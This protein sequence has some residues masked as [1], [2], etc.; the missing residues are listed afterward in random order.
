MYTHSDGTRYNRDFEKVEWTEEEEMEMKE[1]KKRLATFNALKEA[2]ISENMTKFESLLESCEDPN[3]YDG[4]YEP[5]MAT[6]INLA[7]EKAI[8]MLIN[9]GAN[10]DVTTD[11]KETCLTIA[12]KLRVGN[13]SKDVIYSSALLELV[14]NKLDSE[15]SKEYKLMLINILFEYNDNTPLLLAFKSGSKTMTDLIIKHGGDI[16][17]QFFLK[18][19]FSKDANDDECRNIATLLLQYGM[20]PTLQITDAVKN[21]HIKTASLLLTYNSNVEPKISSILRY[22]IPLLDA[23][24]NLDF[25]MA[26]MLLDNGC[27]AGKGNVLKTLM[28]SLNVYYKHPGLK[29]MQATE[30]MA[31]RLIEK[32]CDVNYTDA[33]GET[34]I[35]SLCK[36][37]WD[38][39][40]LVKLLILHGANINHKCMS[41]LLPIMIACFYGNAHIN[42][43]N[44]LFSKGA[45]KNMNDYD[46]R[47]TMN[48]TNNKPIHDRFKAELKWRAR[49]D[50][51]LVKKKSPIFSK[52]PDEMV[53]KVA[54]YLDYEDWNTFFKIQGRRR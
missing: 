20:N 1:K 39:S 38:T 40:D 9:R 49:K 22:D 29:D 21:G 8:T 43:I 23:I 28:T 16:D 53:R 33:L 2:L 19:V 25:D 44:L 10:V 31:Q 17:G 41:G 6:A 27:T 34:P 30:K 4:N 54:C 14:L 11:D 12:F 46:I 37:Y 32:G 5:I 45:L 35:M 26:N 48:K 7:N 24:K 50:L 51:L 47:H 15:V 18:K 42:V 3:I 36:I 52:M 13:N